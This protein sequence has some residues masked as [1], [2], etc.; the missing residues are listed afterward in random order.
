MDY[1]FVDSQYVNYHNVDYHTMNLKREFPGGNFGLCTAIK[2]GQKL[3]A[4]QI[5][6]T[7]L[8]PRRLSSTVIRLRE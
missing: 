7:D 4:E 1:H 3:A 8:V 2:V 5:T 6:R